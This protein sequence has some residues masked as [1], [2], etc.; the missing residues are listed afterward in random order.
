MSNDNIPQDKLPTEGRAEPPPEASTYHSRALA[1][2]MEGQRPYGRFDPERD[3]PTVVGAAPTFA[4][5]GPKPMT[6]PSGGTEGQ[7]GVSVEAVE[8]MLTVAPGGETWLTPEPT[9]EPPPPPQP[10]R[11]RRR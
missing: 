2:A 8:Q 9:P 5:P 7:L 3:G 4:P 1:G 10:P 11:M 6:W